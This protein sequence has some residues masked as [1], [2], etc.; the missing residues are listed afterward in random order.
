LSEKEKKQG[1][2]LLWDRE[3]MRFANISDTDKFSLTISDD[4]TI[5]EDGYSIK[6]MKKLWQNHLLKS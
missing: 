1:W 6:P 5:F 2:T 4:F 3:N